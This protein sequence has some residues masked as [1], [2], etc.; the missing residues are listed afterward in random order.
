V[1]EAFYNLDHAKNENSVILITHSNLEKLFE[2]YSIVN[3]HSEYYFDHLDI[4][5]IISPDM[6]WVLASRKV[7]YMMPFQTKYKPHKGLKKWFLTYIDKELLKR[8][9]G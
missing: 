1:P 2:G 3:I 6:K 9:N 4:D 7:K 8:Y 5:T